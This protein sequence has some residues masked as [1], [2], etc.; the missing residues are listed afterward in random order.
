MLSR[1]AAGLAAISLLPVAYAGSNW[2][3]QIF[4]FSWGDSSLPFPVPTT[5]QCET[6][7]IQWQRGAATGY[8]RRYL[9]G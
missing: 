5:T 3:E 2:L 9:S 6:I 1:F 4:Y 8:V 7:K